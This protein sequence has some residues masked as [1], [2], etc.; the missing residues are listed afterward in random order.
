MVANVLRRLTLICALAAA[1]ALPALALANDAD[2]RRLGQC[3]KSAFSKI[4]LSPENG[5]IEVEFE[6]DASR[7]GQAWRVV[8]RRNGKV[9][10]RTRATTRRPSGSFTVRRVARQP[11]RRA[12]HGSRPRGQPGDDA[13][14]PRRRDARLAPA[15]HSPAV[16]VHCQLA[17]P[18]VGIAWVGAGAGQARVA[19]LVELRVPRRRRQRSLRGCT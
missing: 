4:K 19:L 8:I 18:P 17:V 5:R 13:G 9:D 14:L 10:V 16:S 12:R 7:V 11:P 3:T 6:V 1:A 15:D 2:V